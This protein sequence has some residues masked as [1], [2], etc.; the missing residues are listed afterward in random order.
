MGG[1]YCTYWENRKRQIGRTRR[2]W[3][4]IIKTNF[5]EIG[6]R[7]LGWIDLTRYRNK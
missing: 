5:K 7:G 1:T 2:R 4:D 6:W 3:E